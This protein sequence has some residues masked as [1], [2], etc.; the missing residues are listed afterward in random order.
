M[1]KDYEVFYVD[2]VGSLGKNSQ[3]LNTIEICYYVNVHDMYVIEYSFHSI[4]FDL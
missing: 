3:R 2:C 4:D 1:V